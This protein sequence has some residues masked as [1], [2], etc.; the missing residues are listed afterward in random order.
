VELIGDVAAPERSRHARS[1]PDLP[2]EVEVLHTGFVN[3]ALSQSGISPARRIVVNNR[4]HEPLTGVTI[5][6]SLAAVT[7]QSLAT[8]WE[9]SLSEIQPGQ[10]VTFETID[11]R[12][13]PAA[14]LE[15]EERRPGTL[16]VELFDDKREFRSE[17][18]LDVLA[19]NQWLRFP[20]AETL[21][22][23]TL[24]A[25]AQPNHPAVAELL[26]ETRE[27]LRARTGSPST[28][29][30]QS[31]SERTDEIARAIYEA[32]QARKIAYSN[33]PAS[34]DQDGQKIRTPAQVLTTDRAGTCLDTTVLFAAALEQAGLNPLLWLI[35]GHIFVGWWREEHRR[36][37][38]TVAHEAGAVVNHL[39]LD[40]LGV[41]E[42]T[43]LTDRPEPVAFAEA[44]RK[45]SWTARHAE[46][47]GIVDVYL[48]RRS[49][50]GPLPA[51]HLDAS[52]ARVVV[53][54]APAAPS[55]PP[56]ATPAP[57]PANPRSTTRTSTPDAPP[58]VRRWKNAL[59]D[60]SLRNKLI[61][62]TAGASVTRLNVPEGGLAQV[63]DVLHGGGRLALRAAD[64]IDEVH[65]ARGAMTA[66]QL[67]D[68][69]LIEG[70]R[71]RQLHSDL[72]TDAHG[73]RMRGLQR[74]A[75]TLRE[76]SGSANLYLALGTL[77]WSLQNKALRSPLL[78]LPVTVTPGRRSSEPAT[79]TLDE[80]AE[81]TPNLCLLEKLRQELGLELP[82]LANP[83]VDQYG[84]DVAATFRAVREALAAAEVPFAVRETLDLGVLQFAKFVLWKDLDEHWER[85]LTNPLVRHLV[86][87]PTEA[88]V[89]GLDDTTTDLDA[90]ATKCPVT[91]DA[92]QLDAVARAEAG[93]TFVLEGPPGTG[94]SQTITNVLARTLA[95]GR[96]VLFVAEKRA[97]LDVVRARLDAI[98]LGDLC[99]D[100]HDKASRPAAVREH[101]RR[102]LDTEFSPDAEGHRRAH[103]DVTSRGKALTR[104]VSALHAANGVGHSLYGAH[105]AVLARGDGPV[106]P[107]SQE[108]VSSA[109]RAVID[110]VRRSLPDIADLQ[111]QVRPRRH[112]AWGFVRGGTDRDQLTSAVAMAETARQ[113]LAAAPPTLPTL[114]GA[115]T[116]TRELHLV[117][118]L[119]RPGRPPLGLLD[120]VSS[121]RWQQASTEARQAL[122]R[123]AQAPR[124]IL[125]IATPDVLVL[126]LD[127]LRAEAVAARDGSFL[128]RKKKQQGIVE[129]LRPALWP[130]AQLDPQM[131]VGFLDELLALR[132]E[133]RAAGSGAASLPGV[134]L[135]S[136]W[137][138]LRDEIRALPIG[139]ID[140]LWR[141]ARRLDDVPAGAFRDALR[142]HLADPSAGEP[143]WIGPL[144]R[145]ATGIAVAA[146][147][148]N[149]DGDPDA[150]LERWRDGAPLVEAWSVDAANRRSE[151][152]SSWTELAGLLDPFVE[153]GSPGTADAVLAGAVP[154]DDLVDA[155]E[156]GLAGSSFDERLAASGLAEFD[157]AAHERTIRRFD[158]SS[159]EVRDHLRTAVPHEIVNARDA[160]S[161]TALG[162]VRREANKKR[163]PSVRR[164]MAQ[165]GDAILRVTPCVLVSPE[166][167]A[168]FVDPTSPPFD[169]VVFDEASQIRVA[170]AVGALGRA[171]SAVVV[172][173]SRQM[174]PTAF[175]GAGLEDSEPGDSDDADVPDDEESIL[176]ECVQARVPQ[177][178]LSWHYRSQDE[179][180]IAFSNALY[181]DGRLASF[182]APPSDSTGVSFRRVEGFFQRSGRDGLRTNRIE[183][184][185][186]VDD[187]LRRF[188]LADGEPPSL[189][190]VTFN[191]QQRDLIDELLRATEDPR[192]VE[193][194]DWDDDRGLFVKNLENVQGDERDAVLFS[195]AFSRNEK[196]VLPLN[197][198][199]LNRAGGE[200]RL[201]VAVTR[202]R[203][204]VVVFCSFDPGDLRDS[205]ATGIKHLRAYLEMA[206]YGV[207]ASGDVAPTA[208]QKDRH[209][210]DVA[211]ALRERGLAVRTDVGLSDFRLD[212]TLAHE[213]AP[214]EPVV[215]VL[216]DGPSWA[217]RRTVGDR[218]G[219]PRVLLK[220]VLGWPAVAR[221]WLPRWLSEREGV[222][223]ELAAAVE[224]AHEARDQSATPDEVRLVV[225]DP[226]T[227]IL[228]LEPEV[229]SGPVEPPRVAAAPVASL[230]DTYGGWIPSPE[231]P[232]VVCVPDPAPSPA[233]PD[234]PVQEDG[235]LV[236]TPWPA[237]VA[238]DRS[239]LDRLDEP[240][241]ARQVKELVAEVVDAEAPIEL[242][243]LTRLVGGAFGIARVRQARQDAILDLIPAHVR[244]DREDGFAWPAHRS[245]R[246]WQGYRVS[247]DPQ[248]RPL[249]EIPL[250]EIANAMR[251]A[252]AQNPDVGWNSDEMLRATL[253][254]FGAKRLT[255]GA[256][257]RLDEARRLA[258]RTDG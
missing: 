257:S 37:P 159:A 168:R 107:V 149:G 20:H 41:V 246:S 152:L 131:L 15:M 231:P 223:D 147:S 127:E 212:L 54:Q 184:Q 222:L 186:V 8:P 219:M 66:A 62:L 80:G 78:L 174:P 175:G 12:P 95:Q 38:Q 145:L 122:I 112:H 6:V 227:D 99:L 242:R 9:R 160:S 220:E 164:L 113:E 148:G 217:R 29:G 249:A 31:D 146:E 233:E 64:D 5:R 163:G 151:I 253:A 89:D 50:V 172:G 96:R 75:R 76:E 28:E 256:W 248:S 181:Y 167:L 67:P 161:P 208:S 206:A 123:F 179:S 165:H 215:A 72:S 27:V 17:E 229:V 90:L 101:L 250:V 158:D 243:R 83:P 56:S 178:W 133:A 30:Y 141:M 224:S 94:K 106:L 130:G 126:P 16:V 57:T 173:D 63:E 203:R 193:A 195:I 240:A 138:P 121:A 170:D 132:E 171:R 237:R 85:F 199:P 73:A 18:H 194:L 55:S 91:A 140:E 226:D 228:S 68:D 187:V 200:R 2:V 236:F 213:S 86:E 210:D 211:A 225:D 10:A 119:A 105:D 102:A 245:R 60:L 97:A 191:I 34:W 35:E 129:R 218:D 118:E 150:S 39:D 205:T 207:S 197:F 230:P 202:A 214:D 201:N 58:R 252:Q 92:S 216:L 40:H 162:V 87:S 136:V 241:V 3:Y 13:D 198:G 235:Q 185:A 47:V 258:R 32:L 153:H 82:D 204:Q 79:L 69:M 108:F 26:V 110:A 196:G 177:S 1:A 45:A 116:T 221:V 19:H 84:I 169:V 52:G 182:P 189:G 71:R 48:A 7:G 24:V 188:A 254:V 124:P 209:R 4:D 93:R 144:E 192:V 154:A 155:F 166:S 176:S 49:G 103:D 139:R 128:G 156:R 59:L 14:L 88:F 21:S 36:L 109:S 247:D 134:G 234:L 135:P 22:L 11:L 43:V 111:W 65:R 251:G 25:F 143:R 74:K 51:L 98:G 239:V 137:N 23:E 238:G 114:I 244:V 53:V 117:A 180:L 77:E 104:Y 100:L 232:A 44:R 157:A 70:I 33:P 115:V 46:P 120:E 81:T 190:V 183:A 125:T 61:S 142:A 255:D 42:T